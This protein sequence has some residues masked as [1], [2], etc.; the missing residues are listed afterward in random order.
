[1]TEQSK[2]IGEEI[3]AKINDEVF[4]LDWDYED[5]D[6][7]ASLIDARLAPLVELEKASR[8]YVMSEGMAV[9]ECYRV[10]LAALDAANADAEGGGGTMKNMDKQQ[11]IERI[12]ELEN[13]NHTLQFILT[14]CER[15][16][17]QKGVWDGLP[18][19][20]KLRQDGERGEGDGRA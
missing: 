18:V 16:M 8:R 9:Q 12:K 13:K 14:E 7:A 6:L 19:L 1:M 4:D 17:R 5:I 20:S 10:L 3:A 2:T 11:M 15:Y